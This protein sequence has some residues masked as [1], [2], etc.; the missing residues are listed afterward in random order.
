MKTIITLL[1]LC[2]VSVATFA[3]TDT[4]P[5]LTK[6]FT[7]ANI[8][9][10]NVRTSGG[11]ISV[12]GQNGEASV[13]VYVRS[14]N[15]NKDLSKEELE[16]RLQEY[17]LTVKE[18]GGSIICEVKRKNQDNNWDWK[19]SLSFSFKIKVPEKTTTDLKTSGGSIS[20]KS[21]SGNQVFS[22]S[23]GSL[24][25]EALS[26]NVKGRTSGGS[27]ELSHCQDIL[28]LSTSGGSIK[29]EMCKGDIKLVTSGGSITL[30]QL[31]GNLQART[32]GGSIK[33]SRIKGEL[34]TSTSGGSIRMNDIAAALKASTSG[35]SIEVE[36]TTLGKYLDLSTSSGGISVKM[37]LNSGLDLDL[38]GNRVNVGS[39]SN[40]NGT[41]DKDRVVGKL[42]GGGTAVTMR[43]SSGSV[44]I[45]R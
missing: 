30:N 21:L 29:A 7:A 32:S 15:G 16:D 43:A 22:T 45:N 20:L 44:S 4:K 6:N 40:F 12:T 31:D 3:Q 37:P 2:L 10:L 34:I 14:N 18:E 28:D 19:R 38:R 5:Y 39:L 17:D 13:E 11:S 26:G 42:N 8:K 41:I 36:M 9:N 27:I 35:G 33:G 25:L 1:S 24:H 23:G